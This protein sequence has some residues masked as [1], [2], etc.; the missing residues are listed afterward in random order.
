MEPVI[1]GILIGL[2]IGL[3]MTIVSSAVFY[4]RGRNHEREETP[5]LP[6]D[7]DPHLM[8]LLSE[9]E[10]VE[11]RRVPRFR[12]ES[13]SAMGLLLLTLAAGCAWPELAAAQAPTCISDREI[14][15]VLKS[16]HQ[17]VKVG[18]ARGGGGNPGIYQLWLG[19][20][21][22]TIILAMPGEG[23]RNCILG[24]GGRWSWIQPEKPPEVK[25]G[26]AP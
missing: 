24:A 11:T 4:A 20:D 16:R 13:G 7:E 14:D 10:F 19:P 22:M 5:S 6:L 23:R 12:T 21:S 17:E 26:G 3:I 18:N 1:V 25:I 9:R 15:E 2:L 8:R